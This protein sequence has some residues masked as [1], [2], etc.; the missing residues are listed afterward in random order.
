MGQFFANV[1]L[2][3]QHH[4]VATGKQPQALIL[5][6][7]LVMFVVIRGI[8]HRIHSRSDQQLKDQQQK[9]RLL[10]DFSVGG[11]HIHH[12]VW[13]ILLLLLTG[14]LMIAF[15]LPSLREPLAILFGFGAALTLDEF[16]LWLRL[17]D[18]YWTKEGRRSVDVVIIVAVIL[19]FVMLGW[20]FWQA[21]GREITH[22]FA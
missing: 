20:P 6:S 21:V 12:L 7:F 3:Y 13:G 10:H 2:L 11:V 8:T 18:V 14:Y 22:M 5:L 16:A 1:A 15:D 9:R 17:E 19:A 4:I